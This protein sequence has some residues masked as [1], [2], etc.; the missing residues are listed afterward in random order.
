[1]N[2]FVH[3]EIQSKAK[4]S[5]VITSV[6]ISFEIKAIKVVASVHCL[7]YPP[8]TMVWLLSLISKPSIEN[9]PVENPAAL[10]FLNGCL[11]EISL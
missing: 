8:S 2:G 9:S 5:N 11:T 3:S 1:M 6:L 4:W 10:L 7:D